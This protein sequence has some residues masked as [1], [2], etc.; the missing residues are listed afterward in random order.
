MPLTRNR[1][2]VSK[3]QV[4]DAEIPVKATVYAFSQYQ[5]GNPEEST[6]PAAVCFPLSS[7]LR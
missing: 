4:T 2:P 5:V 7:P 3:L 1:Y 6:T